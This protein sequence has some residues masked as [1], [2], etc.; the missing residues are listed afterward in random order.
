[1]QVPAS[2]YANWL[3]QARMAGAIAHLHG[4]DVTSERIR[5]IVLLSLL[6]D[7]ALG[8]LKSMGVRAAEAATRC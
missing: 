8:V 2:V 6:G 1:M 7:S 5:S 4:H 3:V